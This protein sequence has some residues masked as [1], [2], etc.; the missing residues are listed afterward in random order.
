MKCIIFTNNQKKCLELKAILAGYKLDVLRYTDVLDETID[1]IED[2]DSFEANAL[3]KVNAIAH[4][5]NA[6][7]IADDSGLEIECLNGEPG[8]YSAR[9]GGPDLSDAQRCEYVLSNVGNNKNRG[10]QF[11]CVIALIFPNGDQY[12]VEGK[13]VGELTHEPK[14]AQGFGYDPLFIP[15]GYH[16]TFAELGADIKHK[17]SHRGQALAKATELIKAYLKN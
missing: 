15:Q 16:E 14:G 17:I 2:G 10:A 5:E 3:K 12:C 7:L 8:I 1:V 6:I 13:V 4:I 11:R 9:Y